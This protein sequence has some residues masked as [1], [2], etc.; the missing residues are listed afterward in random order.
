MHKDHPS[1]KNKSSCLVSILK[2][3]DDLAESLHYPTSRC[4]LAKLI[5]FTIRVLCLANSHGNNN[6]S[7]CWRDHLLEGLVIICP[8]GAQG[9][10]I[11]PNVNEAHGMFQRD[12]DLRPAVMGGNVTETEIHRSMNIG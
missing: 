3:L 9:T 8:P 12:L 1:M 6:R 4:L 5:V 10:D 2:D 7:G 11:L